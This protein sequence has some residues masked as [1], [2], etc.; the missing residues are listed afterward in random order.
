MVSQWWKKAS[1]SEI[2]KMSAKSSLLANKKKTPTH[3]DEKLK[4]LEET[5]AVSRQRKRVAVMNST[6]LASVDELWKSFSDTDHAKCW[7]LRAEVR[8]ITRDTDLAQAFYL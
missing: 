4:S 8:T 7:T 3:Q 5:A 1:H 6:A 2:K